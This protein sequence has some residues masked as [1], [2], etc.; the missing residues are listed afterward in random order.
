MQPS[1][2]MYSGI[3]DNSRLKFCSEKCKEFWFP[4]TNQKSFYAVPY[5]D[6]Y[7]ESGNTLAPLMTFISRNES[8][9]E[10][11]YLF[12]DDASE[13]LKKLFIVWQVRESKSQHFA[14]FYI[15]KDCFPLKSVWV[16]Q[17]CSGKSRATSYLTTTKAREL[18]THFMELFNEAVKH[19]GF[20]NF[21]EFLINTLPSFG[22]SVD[23][24]FIIIV[25]MSGQM[26]FPCRVMCDN[27]AAERAKLYL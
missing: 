4:P 5:L 23:G 27:V 10:Q 16:K 12:V 3:L 19:N 21:E 17:I 24:K 22:M 2:T 6:D 20:D 25:W 26:S 11:I 15:T 9:V 13:G 1:S 14:H 7:C 18:Q 8:G